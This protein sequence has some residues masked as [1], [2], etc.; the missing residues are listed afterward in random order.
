[1]KNSDGSTPT[2]E[3]ITVG[4][5]MSRLGRKVE[6]VNLLEIN[7]Y[8]RSSKVYW[9]SFSKLYKLLSLKHLVGEKDQ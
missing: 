9:L 4:E 8:L 2:I 7:T 3:V 6:G 1:V 5:L